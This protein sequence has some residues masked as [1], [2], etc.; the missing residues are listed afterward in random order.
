[1]KN[2]FVRESFEFYL[3]TCVRLELLNLFVLSQF[4]SL[5]NKLH[6]I[7]VEVKSYLTTNM[8]INVILVMILLRLLEGRLMMKMMIS[9]LVY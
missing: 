8:A 2:K 5:E 4:L 7:G 1:M 9:P 3:L 6:S